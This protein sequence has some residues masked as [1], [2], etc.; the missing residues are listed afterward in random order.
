MD[1]I[2]AYRIYPGTVT[3]LT[4][5][6]FYTL[7]YGLSSPFEQAMTRRDSLTGDWYDTSAHFLWIGDRTRFEGSAHVEFLRGIG[8]PVGVKCGPSLDPDVLL[9]LLDTLNPARARPYHAHLTL[10]L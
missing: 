10:R 3:Q 5:T 8:N 4:R 7:P 2:P 9:R 6:P 1:L